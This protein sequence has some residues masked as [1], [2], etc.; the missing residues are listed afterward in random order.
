MARSVCSVCDPQITLPWLEITACT[1]IKLTSSGL[2]TCS[3]AETYTVKRLAWQDVREEEGPPAHQAAF[4]PCK[5]DKGCEAA[6]GEVN[7]WLSSSPNMH[8]VKRRCE[9][10]K[11]KCKITPANDPAAGR[12]IFRIS[13]DAQYTVAPW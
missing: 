1:T 6:W 5:E 9:Q 13:K 12:A 3:L 11:R 4:I 10:G 7:D 2:V 8:N